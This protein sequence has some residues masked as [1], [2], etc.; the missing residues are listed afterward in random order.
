M[1]FNIPA[2]SYI[3]ITS[4][5]EG[6][7][8][9]ISS[10]QLEDIF[11]GDISTGTVNP[12][13]GVTIL[14]IGDRIHNQLDTSISVTTETISVSGSSGSVDLSNY[15]TESQIISLIDTETS[16]KVDKTFSTSTQ[17]I[18][19]S[20]ITADT[21]A[22]GDSFSRALQADG[23]DAV[24]V[25]VIH[26]PIGFSYDYL[27]QNGW[28]ATTA[29]PSIGT[30]DTVIDVNLSLS[31]EREIAYSDQIQSGINGQDG[32]DGAQGPAGPTGPAGP[33]GLP[34]TP[35]LP[36]PQGERGPQGEQG[37]QGIQGETGPAGPAGADGADGADGVDA[38]SPT[39]ATVATSGSYNDLSD[40]PDLDFTPAYYQEENIN[41]D[42]Q[43]IH[44]GIST[45]LN[46]PDW[47]RTYQVNG[48]D[49]VTVEVD[50]VFN[51]GTNDFNIRY[52]YLNGWEDGGAG[53]RPGSIG[54]YPGRYGGGD[55]TCLLYTSPSP[56]D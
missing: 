49:A 56:R 38:I 6:R 45:T 4:G 2:S 14:E 8:T 27:Y 34:G 24:L 40:Q 5:Q 37:D 36:G 46:D 12:E 53:T 51:A 21:A 7:I 33:E 3:T 35:G 43:L 28:T 30:H 22:F 25:T 48:E 39:L 44:D 11:V 1:Q 16:D 18:T 17:T 31:K 54:N 41:V 47:S 50:A 15:R 13:V 19:A 55:N 52:V 9:A 42:A 20:D 23:E 29:A 32:A 26:L 10:T